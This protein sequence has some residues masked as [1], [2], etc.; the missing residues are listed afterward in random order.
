MYKNRYTGYR[1]TNYKVKREK[2]GKKRL[3]KQQKDKKEDLASKS[4]LY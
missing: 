1:K 2:D 3:L 4:P